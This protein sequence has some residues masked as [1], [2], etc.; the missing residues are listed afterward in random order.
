MN[1]KVRVSEKPAIYG[2]GGVR[3]EVGGMCC[4]LVH[5]GTPQPMQYCGKIISLVQSDER[6]TG[7]VEI[8]T[9]AGDKVRAP[10]NK[11]Y[12]HSPVATTV[13]DDFGPVTIW[14]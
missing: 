12:D 1:Y 9:L 11:V 3:F 10:A 14:V 6:S 7:S 4:I 8:V 13:V 5:T 2:V